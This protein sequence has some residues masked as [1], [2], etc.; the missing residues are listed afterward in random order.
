V[1]HDSTFVELDKSHHDRA[2]FDCGEEPLNTFIQTQAAKHMLSGISRTMVLPE[3]MKLANNKRRIC[4]FYS[5]APSAIR[6]D[7]LPPALAKKLPGYPVP[8][9]LIAQLAVQ[10]VYHGCGLGK[11]T[12]L[13]ALETLWKIN[14]NMRAYAVIVDCLTPAAESFYAKFGFKKL[15]ADSRHTRMFITMKTIKT[16]FG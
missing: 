11:V 1:R 12:L 3:T 13:S 2:S 10:S 14:E 7:N 4:A 15:A 5:I 16:L 8:V 6:Q 9:F